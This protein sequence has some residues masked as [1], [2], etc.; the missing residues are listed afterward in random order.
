MHAS[1]GVSSQ[2]LTEQHGEG[3]LPH[4]LQLD[5]QRSA[6]QRDEKD[7]MQHRC[8]VQGLLAQ[9][10][11]KDSWHFQDGWNFQSDW[12]H[13]LSLKPTAAALSRVRQKGLAEGRLG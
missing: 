13:D 7:V 5:S 2:K 12:Q 10:D 3:M 8:S 1:K 9:L 11:W 6:L 4:F